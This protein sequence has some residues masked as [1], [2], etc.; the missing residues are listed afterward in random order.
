MSSPLS[1]IKEEQEFAYQAKWYIDR[2]HIVIQI[3]EQEFAWTEA[4]K[5]IKLAARALTVPKGS[6]LN[7]QPMFCFQIMLKMW[8]WLPCV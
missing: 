5:P 8:Y 2:L 4:D 1:S 7:Q 3:W 6:S